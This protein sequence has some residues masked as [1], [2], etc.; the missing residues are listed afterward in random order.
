MGQSTSQFANA[1]RLAEDGK[2]DLLG[3]ISAAEALSSSGQ[4]ELATV[5]YK[6]W[7]LANS[8]HPL[9]YAAAFN[10]GSQLLANGDLDG[11]KKFLLQAIAVNPE[12]SQARV[13]LANVYER[14]G[15]VDAALAT[16]QEM[17]DRLSAVTPANVS[18]KVLAL[19]NIA[20]M[21]RG[22]ETAETALRQAIELD[23][24]QAEVVQHWVN[25]R[26]TRCVWP[27]LEPVGPLDV[28]AILALMAPLS[29]CIYTDDANQQLCAAR[30]Q[31]SRSLQGATVTHG[32]WPMPSDPSRAKLQIGYVS[33]D[34]CNHAVGYLIS[35][36]FTFHDSKRFEITVYNIGERTDDQ[37]QRKI[38]G[39]VDR[40]VDIRGVPD[41][42]AAA[43]IQGHGIDIL[44]DMNGH[45]NYQRTQLLAMKPA[46]I[47]V[48]WLGY[49]G[50]M[51][52]TFH[53]YIIG[54]DFIIPPSHEKY[55]SERVARL[56]CYQP[57]SP[58]YPMPE[59]SRSRRE[60]GL[61]DDAIVY[62]CFNGSIKISEPIFSS[63]MEILKQVPDGVL[64]LRGS[65]ADAERKLREEAKLRD[66]LPER[67]IFLPF[68]SNT[69]YLASHRYADIF[70][71]TFPYGA[72]TTASDALR[73]G[74]PI[75]TL[76][77]SSFA[78]RV[79]G[80]LS[81]AAGLP[82]F[83]FESLSDYTGKAIELGKDRELLA[84]VKKQLIEARSECDLFNIKLLA[85]RLESLFEGMWD[86]YC[87]GELLT[88]ADER[89]ARG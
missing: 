10:C 48:N 12:F 16:W 50:T 53:D 45:T 76:V 55:Y 8:A 25:S 15:A 64:W 51:G 40:W 24:S 18:N 73:A 13:N 4:S 32:P 39:N 61:P 89:S 21:R 83:A 44:V 37:L 70:V 20:R 71:D 5:L 38:V 52:S 69:E 80:S 54:D 85:G 9:R 66:V 86:S 47:L 82:G 63:W 29:V 33:S 79:C 88:A 74:I 58:P 7:L 22:T 17:S 72:H 49:P 60:L 3:L 62:C 11:A 57:N 46:P 41:E 1:V 65:T 26:Q 27:T 14:M 43:T 19:K 23:P 68:Q 84:Q 87:R 36:L 78:S 34:F 81:R 31:I 75:V 28:D 35:D 2:L 30:N 42:A 77:G 56:P 59:P 67:L 6:F